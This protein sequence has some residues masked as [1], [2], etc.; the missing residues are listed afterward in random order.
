MLYVPEGHIVIFWYRSV[1]YIID[2]AAIKP[3][4]IGETLPYIQRKIAGDNSITIVANF[5]PEAY[6]CHYYNRGLPD[7]AELQITHVTDAKSYLAA[8]LKE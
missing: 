7:D 1:P 8:L 6:I 4:D 2:N 3:S 5:I